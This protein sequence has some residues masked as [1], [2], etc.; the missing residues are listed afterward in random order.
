MK[1]RDAGLKE[2]DINQTYLP[3]LAGKITD[4]FAILAITVAARL[5]GATL[6]PLGILLD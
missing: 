3:G 2:M 4:F 6:C 1:R 5:D